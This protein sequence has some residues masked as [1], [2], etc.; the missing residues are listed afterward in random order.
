MI[1]HI[2]DKN[3]TNISSNAHDYCLDCILNC[4]E[5]S[6]KIKCSTDKRQRRIGKTI[7]DNIV[8]FLCNEKYVKSSKLFRKELG[9]LKEFSL[10][11]ESLKAH[12]FKDINSQIFR[13]LHN[14]ITYNAHIL[15]DIYSIIPQDELSKKGKEIVKAIET[16]LTKGDTKNAVSVLRILKN[17]N[18]MK[19]EFSIFKKLYEPNPIINTMNHEIHKV[20]LLVFNSFWYDLI[21]NGNYINIQNCNESIPVDYESVAAALAHVIDNTTK[22]IMPNTELNINFTSSQHNLIL[23]FDMMSLEIKPDEIDKVFEDGYS[24]EVPRKHELNGKGV[25][26][27][28]VK[29][30]LTLNNAEIDISANHKRIS[31][32]SLNGLPYQ[33]NIIRVTF[34]KSSLTI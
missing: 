32:V 25:G 1:C 4:T 26:L 8:I 15:Q 18:L 22:Y 6:I 20:V 12:A 9:L 28:M 31:P 16:V 30:L 33:N 24:G 5:E 11:L 13:L 23:S 19:A 21:Q 34:N 29:R 3:G 27:Y 14:L 7:N 17:A 10:N 2:T